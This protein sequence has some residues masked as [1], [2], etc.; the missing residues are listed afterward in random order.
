MLAARLRTGEGTYTCAFRDSDGFGSL[1]LVEAARAMPSF[2]EDGRARGTL[3][4]HRIRAEASAAPGDTSVIEV[5]FD[6]SLAREVHIAPSTRGG[7]NVAEA[8]REGTEDP[9]LPERP[10]SA[11]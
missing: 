9:A 1:T 5:R 10:P 3:S 2:A 11:E 6:F 4:L 8:V 7:R